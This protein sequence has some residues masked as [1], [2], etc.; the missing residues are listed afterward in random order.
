MKHLVLISVPLEGQ[1]S[2]YKKKEI[3]RVLNEFRGK[4]V[5]MTIEKRY[6]KRSNNQNRYLWGCC[7]PLIQQGFL[8]GG[9]KVGIEAV[10]EFL[11][12]RFLNHEISNINTGEVFTMTKSTTELT[13]AQMMDYVSEIQQFAAEY[14]NVV[15]PDPNSQTEIF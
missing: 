9:N 7:Y 13:T 4:N 1:I 3:G 5:M 11:K 15:I 6:N 8:D 2:D 10:H 14:L 12:G